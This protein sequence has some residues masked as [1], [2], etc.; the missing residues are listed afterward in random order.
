MADTL[1][2]I[3]GGTSGIGRAIAL[4]LAAEGMRVTVAGRDAA[5]GKAVAED[6]GAAG[7][8]AAAFLPLAVEPLRALAEEVGATGSAI[9]SLCDMV[10]PLAGLQYSIT[11]TKQVGSRKSR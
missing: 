4:R 1:A 6:C 9:E 5:R 3:I 8:S 10:L 7:A 11:Q 2:L